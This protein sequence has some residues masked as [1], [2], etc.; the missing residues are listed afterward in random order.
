MISNK[1]PGPS[2]GANEVYLVWDDEF[3]S[4]EERRASLRKYQ[5]LDET[6]QMNSVDDAID[7][8]ILEGRLAGR[9]SF[10]V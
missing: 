2:G 3:L 10:H 4:M 1:P 8:R 6:L 9:M 7:R 5:T